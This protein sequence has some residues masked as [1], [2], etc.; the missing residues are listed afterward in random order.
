MLIEPEKGE[1][2]NLSSA[3]DSRA[4]RLDRIDRFDRTC[5]R[6]SNLERFPSP[7][8]QQIPQVGRGVSLV[9]LYLTGSP[10]GASD[11]DPEKGA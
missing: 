4:S 11:A 9:I 1:A 2:G 7:T 8:K 3:A 10:S 6:I 5:Q